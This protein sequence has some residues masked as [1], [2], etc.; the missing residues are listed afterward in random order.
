MALAGTWYTPVPV[1]FTAGDDGMFEGG[2]YQLVLDKFSV[3]LKYGDFELP[4]KVASDFAQIQFENGAK[5]KRQILGRCLE[6]NEQP[7]VAEQSN[8]LSDSAVQ[9]IV[10]RLNSKI[11]IW[12]LSESME[13]SLLTVF[14]QAGNAQ[15]KPFLASSAGAPWLPVL[16]ALLDES[17]S[18]EE[19]YEVVQRAFATQVRDPLV[20]VLN[21]AIDIPC[22]GEGKEDEL[23]TTLV[24]V[25]VDV[26][27]PAVLDGLDR[28]GAS[29]DPLGNQRKSATK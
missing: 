20:D 21:G 7:E 25:L 6:A 1:D 5:W 10:D 11:D 14:V 18:R 16:E 2:D 9:N 22:I 17:K 26:L 27:V 23:L 15:L 3:T 28:T 12:L 8:L 4:G 13:A 19:T 29:V 24:D